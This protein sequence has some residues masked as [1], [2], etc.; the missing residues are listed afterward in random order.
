VPSFDL[1]SPVA[2]EGIS[3][4]KPTDL[5]KKKVEISVDNLGTV[6]FT[7]YADTGTANTS[8]SLVLDSSVNHALGTGYVGG[9]NTRLIVRSLTIGNPS[10]INNLIIHDSGELRFKA[11]Y[12]NAAETVLAHVSAGILTING[13]QIQTAVTQADGTEIGLQELVAEVAALR[14]EIAELRGR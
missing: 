2:G 13:Q 10:P 6:N 3:I 9:S 12:S 7:N 14:A 8:G 1:K 4:Y 11:S 5:T